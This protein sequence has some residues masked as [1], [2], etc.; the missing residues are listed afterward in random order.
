MHIVNKKMNNLIEQLN[1]LP[2]LRD[3]IYE[4]VRKWKLQKITVV[5]RYPI[6]FG[7]IQNDIEILRQLIDARFYYSPEKYILV[8]KLNNY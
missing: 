8:V 2:E 1:D 7:S 6:M 3:Y 5:K 4:Q